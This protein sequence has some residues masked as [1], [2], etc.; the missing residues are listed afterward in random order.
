[1]TKIEA[2]ILDPISRMLKGYAE[3][4]L[5]AESDASSDIDPRDDTPLGESYSI[6]DIEWPVLLRMRED[7]EQFARDNDIELGA[8]TPE[9]AGRWFWL[10]RNGH[11]SGF[12]DDDSLPE[13]VRH[14]LQTAAE[15]W[16]DQGLMSND[17]GRLTFI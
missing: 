4:A 3:A 5:F 10:S 12:F 6:E 8:M 11:G 7:C 14:R 15:K 17:E 16:P 13:E 9:T 2:S 1:M